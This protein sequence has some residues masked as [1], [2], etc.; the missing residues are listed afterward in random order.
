MYKRQDIQY[1]PASTFFGTI[2]PGGKP[3]TY[4]MAEFENNYGYDADD[5]SQF[6]CN[7]IPSAANSFGGGNWD[8]YCNPAVDALFKQEQSTADT[9]MRQ[10]AFDQLHQIYLTDYPFVTLYAPTDLAVVKNNTHNYLPG[11]GG[12]AE[13]VNLWTWWCTGGTC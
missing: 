3:G 11:P 1:Y 5:S 13:T 4:D 12:A 7:Q 10:Q 9:T 2:L 8:W 6:A